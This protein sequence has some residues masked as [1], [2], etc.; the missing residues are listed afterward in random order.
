MTT[1]YST[2]RG[3]RKPTNENATAEITLLIIL[4]KGETKY[5]VTK[6]SIRFSLDILELIDLKIFADY[7]FFN[8]NP[9]LFFSAVPEK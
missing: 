8:Q 6:H 9:Y 7:L 4:N 5:L 2:S 1:L 3:L